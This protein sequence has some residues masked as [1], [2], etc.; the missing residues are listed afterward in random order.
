MS[1]NK[2]LLLLILNVSTA[3]IKCQEGNYDSLNYVNVSDK[4]LDELPNVRNINFDIRER[5]LKLSAPFEALEYESETGGPLTCGS[6]PFLQL[7]SIIT[8][9]IFQRKDLDPISPMNSIT[10]SKTGF[11]CK[12]IYETKQSLLD[13]MNSIINYYNEFGAQFVKNYKYSF[14]KDG[15][16]EACKEFVNEVDFLEKNDLIMSPIVKDIDIMKKEIYYN[17]SILVIYNYSS[18]FFRYT[19]GG[20]YVEDDSETDKVGFTVLKVIGWRT[21]NNKLFWVF[22]YTRNNDW[23][24]KNFG[25]MED[26]S[27]YNF[28]YYSIKSKEA[29][30]N[31]Q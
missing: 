30:I 21:I 6:N 8:E 15:T 26:K 9:K 23:G 11:T 13:E 1:N 16:F 4:L 3:L 19:S 10:C 24:I 12:N 7:S 31:I 5:N 29:T 20:I 2:V 17:G 27:E 18:K 25:M 22:S 14:N 28:D